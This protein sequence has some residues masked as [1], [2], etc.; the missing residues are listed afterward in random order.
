MIVMLSVIMIVLLSVIMI[1]MLSVIMIV[2]LS[3]MM[4][5][6]LNAIMI[7]MCH[8]D[9]HAECHKLAA[10]MLSA[11]LLKAIRLCDFNLIVVA[12]PKRPA[13]SKHCRLLRPLASYEE[14]RVFQMCPQHSDL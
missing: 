11:I 12:P 7:V 4:M 5:V 9:S 8:N 6:M 2:M 10:L 3:V 14:N 1:V 13:R